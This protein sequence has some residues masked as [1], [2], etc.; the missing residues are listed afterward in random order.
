MEYPT[1]QDAAAHPATAPSPMQ[2]RIAD[3]YF[4]AIARLGQAP[5]RKLFD[6]GP[7]R[8][9]ERQMARRAKEPVARNVPLFFGGSMTV[10]LPEVISEQLHGY[11]LFDDVVTWMA[12]CAL[13]PGDTVLD[14]GAHFGY[15]SLL[16][17]A[18]AGPQGRVFSFEPT[19]STHALLARNVAGLPGVV[20]INAA[21]GDAEGMLTIRDYG[22]KFSAWNTLAPDGRLGPQAD[23]SGTAPPAGVQ[24]Q[25]QTLDG[26][27]AARGLVPGFIKIDAENYETEVLDGAAQLLRSAH[28]TLLLETG[29]PRA[30]SLA[31]R[32]Q[33]TGYRA[34]AAEAP[35]RLVECP[36]VADAALHYKDV[37]YASGERAV[38]L[39]D[40]ARALGRAGHRAT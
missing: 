5:W 26:L 30:A 19:P 10:M 6:P 8:F 15:F 35:G 33:D 22:L 25:V 16:F 7:R 14:V 39:L 17:A 24:V 37:L 20:A 13:E 29:S 31:R 27:A 1:M 4:R 28:P 23:G 2:L 32:L 36:D 18:L 11:G 9:I 40:R 38:R 3:A 34:F 21:A 12:L